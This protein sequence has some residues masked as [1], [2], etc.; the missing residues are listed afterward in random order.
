PGVEIGSDRDPRAPLSQRAGEP[1]PRSI[2]SMARFGPGK[3]VALAIDAFALLREQIASQAFASLRLV[4]AGGYDERLE[5]SRATLAL[6]QQRAAALRIADQVRFV[7]SPG[8]AERRE[9][10]QSCECAV[11][12]A[13]NEHFGYAP[14]EGMRARRPVVAVNSGGPAETVVDGETGFLRPATPEAFA[15][16]LRQ[17]LAEPDRARRMGEAGRARVAERF[18]RAA[19][20]ARLEQ[21]LR[22]VVE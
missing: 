1:A 20:G 2:L 5:E 18:S 3:N 6:L 4:I 16:A 15:G 22:E 19:F 14:L 12:T 17:L 11:H 9:L 10:V 13:P 7:P 21:V 8:D